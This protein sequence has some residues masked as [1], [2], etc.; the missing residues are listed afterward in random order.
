MD[1]QRGP[2]GPFRR[3][4]GLH[5]VAGSDVFRRFGKFRVV[6]NRD[7]TGP[8]N[9]LRRD[10]RA[11]RRAPNIWNRDRVMSIELFLQLSQ[12]QQ[13]YRRSLSVHTAMPL[14]CYVQLKFLE[15]Q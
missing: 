9:K 13:L 11:T 6:G 8:T 1:L 10:P 2:A 7:T 4:D 3:S 15:A 12:G 5:C 14:H